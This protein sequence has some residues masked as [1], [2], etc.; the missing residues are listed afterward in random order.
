M[1]RRPSAST[2]SSSY[3]PSAFPPNHP[4][5]TP[6][7]RTPPMYPSPLPHDASLPTAVESSRS[8]TTSPST[9]T[10]TLTSEGNDRRGG[11]LSSLS[12]VATT[13]SATTASTWGS[14]EDSDGP[15]TPELVTPGGRMMLDLAI[16]AS[17]GAYAPPA[18]EGRRATPSSEL[19]QPW[20]LPLARDPMRAP[21][22]Y[23]FAPSSPLESPADL[24]GYPAPL[25]SPPNLSKPSRPELA[26]PD[27]QRSLSTNNVEPHQTSRIHTTAPTPK[28]RVRDLPGRSM[29]LGLYTE[30]DP[31]S[32]SRLRSKT[33]E[34]PQRSSQRSATVD[35]LRSPEFVPE[36]SRAL[37]DVEF[38][39][40]AP[41][42]VDPEE[43]DDEETN[44][45]GALLPVVLEGHGRRVRHEESGLLNSE[46]GA[47]SSAS[48]FLSPRSHLHQTE[49]HPSP[50]SSRRFGSIL[51]SPSASPDL[52]A[53]SSNSNKR[54]SMLFNL[55]GNI[56]S[57]SRSGSNK[58][59]SSSGNLPSIV[60]EHESLQSSRSRSS[61]SAASL[62]SRSSTFDDQMHKGVIGPGEKEEGT[63]EDEEEDPFI[64]YR[65]TS[66]EQP[67]ARSP[68]LF[69]RSPTPNIDA[70]HHAANLSP[71]PSTRGGESRAASLLNVFEAVGIA[72]PLTPEASPRPSPHQVSGHVFP[73][74][75]P[76]PSY[77]ARSP[78][79]PLSLPPRSA[80]LL[81]LAP[82]PADEEDQQVLRVTLAA[83]K[84]GRM[85]DVGVGPGQEVLL[86]SPQPVGSEAAATTLGRLT[87]SPPRSWS[88]SG[89]SGLASPR[90][91]AQEQEREREDTALAERRH[92]TREDSQ[93]S[94]T[95]KDLEWA[96][97]L[98]ERIASGKGGP[99]PRWPAARSDIQEW[100]VFA[101]DVF[102]LSD[103]TTGFLRKSKM[104]FRLRFVTITASPSPAIAL[105]VA[106]SMRPAYHLHSYRERAGG[107]RETARIQLIASSI[108]CVPMESE[109]P[110]RS[111]SKS[112]SVSKAFALKVTGLGVS[113]LDENGIP[114]RKEQSWILGM[115]DVETLKAWMGRVKAIVNELKEPDS[116]V[117]LPT[118]PS[119]R[120]EGTQT[121][122]GLEDEPAFPLGAAQ[123]TIASSSRRSTVSSDARSS[124]A[125]DG[126][127]RS[128][129]QREGSMLPR[130]GT[131]PASG[132]SR[133]ASADAWI[134]APQEYS[135]HSPSSQVY[136][137]RMRSPEPL[138]LGASFFH[139]NDLVSYEEED[140]VAN[141][142]RYTSR[143]PRGNFSPPLTPI[144]S[145][146]LSPLRHGSDQ[147]HPSPLSRPSQHL[148]AL[149]PRP[150]PSTTLPPPP[151][152]HSPSAHSISTSSRH[153]SPSVQTHTDSQSSASGHSSYA[154]SQNRLSV[155]SAGSGE[156]IVGSFPSAPP[157]SPPPPTGASPLLSG[158]DDRRPVQLP[159]MSAPPVMPPRAL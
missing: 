68:S 123:R 102:K 81:P 96:A 99:L 19:A 50:S 3:F 56:S 49:L 7:S 63:E 132:R 107:V 90:S 144:H 152:P 6:P 57:L 32:K 120:A 59:S 93:A 40:V 72:G 70:E 112:S 69:P 156:V 44:V 151:L 62:R 82:A 33:E 84:A 75:S 25:P 29:H 133:M 111:D 67:R 48:S 77:S 97:K 122:Q 149:P 60:D 134:P 104:T 119:M 89:S 35:V 22:P 113:E 136:A 21:S 87:K 17:M 155:L 141:V 51:S 140:D 8:R 28:T 24:Q 139:A 101:D 34:L 135:P 31:P 2:A 43:L 117:P 114:T 85:L 109:V 23:S 4:L 37:R 86:R 12:D 46:P 36:G 27:R 116:P 66:P 41:W 10:P 18:N 73:A 76:R 145:P 11:A 30:P 74:R 55:A 142:Q 130:S 92:R 53:T 118:S 124:T 26:R 95:Q 129:S 150:P 15:L 71:I 159:V 157:L 100:E 38:A 64:R 5:A 154:K 9:R 153:R 42:A 47:S 106:P 79:P 103:A 61:E 13:M 128:L 94:W 65:F 110:S 147:S 83:K 58:S 88:D 98:R 78:P 20:D 45:L 54:H 105:S 125:S 39:A 14:N 1:G 108:V 131:G 121:N 158:F 127:R 91:S 52:S 80:S 137:R 143:L 148:H 146:R 115:D 138:S 16:K 126:I